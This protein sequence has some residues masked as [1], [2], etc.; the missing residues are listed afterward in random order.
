MA[1]ELQPEGAHPPFQGIIP[2]AQELHRPPHRGRKAFH[3]RCCVPYH[4]RRQPAQES[5]QQ[6][7]CPWVPPLRPGPH[8]SALSLAVRVGP[9]RQGG[10]H[11]VRLRGPVDPQ[12]QAPGYSATSFKTH[13]HE[14][15]LRH[16]LGR[17]L[18]L[19]IAP[20]FA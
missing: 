16:L 6:S 7:W 5:V 8:I 11:R 20:L 17:G 1:Q 9:V 2:A 13:R 10:L 18:A 15:Q 3:P 12:L 14:E 19:G 4:L